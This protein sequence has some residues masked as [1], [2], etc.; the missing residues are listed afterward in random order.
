ME[1]NNGKD[2]TKRKHHDNNRVNLET[3]GLVGVE[4]EHGGRR[5]AGTDR[6]CGGGSL[7]SLGLLSLGVV[8]SP[9]LVRKRVAVGHERTT[10]VWCQE[11]NR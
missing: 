9:G 3:L 8:S 1:S 10:T 7:G 2:E 11:D 6:P 4:L 5:A